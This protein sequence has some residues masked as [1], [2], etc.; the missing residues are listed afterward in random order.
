MSF[1]NKAQQ[2]KRELKVRI[3]KPLSR[4]SFEE[5]ETAFQGLRTEKLSDFDGS[6]TLL[7]GD[8][9]ILDF[10]E[11]AV[12]YLSLSVSCPDSMI[13]DSPVTLG[14]YFGEFPLEIVKENYEG[15]LGSG[16]LQ[17]EERSAV[18][19]PAS[20]SLDRRYSFRFLKIKRLD[21]AAFPIALENIIAKC[22]SAVDISNAP[23]L[24]TE[25]EALKRIYEMSLRTLR[26][27]EQDVFEDGPKRDRR[28]W[29][30]DLRLQALVDYG[31]FK[32]LDLVKR[33]I[34]L[35]AGYLNSKGEVVPCVYPDSPPYRL[36][37][38]FAD[39][40]LFLISCL[41]DYYAATGDKAL[42]EEV[43]GVA[44]AQAD[45]ISK[46]LDGDLQSVA[47]STFI[48]WCPGLDKSCALLGV[49]IYT[50]RQLETLSSVL[51]KECDEIVAE[52]KKR[53]SELRSFYKNGVFITPAGQISV[54]SQVWG[55]LSGV[56]TD[57][58]GRA[59]L[60]GLDSLDTEFTPRT[61]YMI[62][63][64]IEALVTSG[65]RDKALEV[66]KDIWGRIADA[67]FDTCPEIFNPKND[68]E[69]PYNAP[70]INSACHA[71]S[72]T[73]AY[74]IKYLEENNND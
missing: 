29:I 19:T 5:D 58:K 70:E 20:L 72:C 34:Y 66:I 9:I 17:R 68:F 12:G 18:F 48:D 26:D 10:G 50:L 28:L 2:L 56:L 3:L 44:K 14:F 46:R 55:V 36:E 40:S 52:R 43:Y 6:A 64:Y 25:D 69:S 1:I 23:R 57:E 51:G 62:H 27:C 65:L 60:E 49:F 35:F 61:P 41:Y 67:G 4:V 31:T 22:V 21:S 39:Y 42:V 15:L 59:L 33:C 74:W 54:H 24:D 8:E 7:S 71:W 13:S 47:D 32:N 73:P 30:G 16:W 53:E 63:Y 38:T 37:W 11:H 45:I